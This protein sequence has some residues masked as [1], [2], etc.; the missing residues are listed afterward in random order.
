MAR[1]LA[2]KGN[3]VILM[4]RLAR[5]A[6]LSITIALLSVQGARAQGQPSS[7]SVPELPALSEECGT[8]NSNTVELAPLPSTMK[9]IKERKS[10][11]I[12]A[13]GS[14]TI[15]TG[16]SG[17]DFQSTLERSLE[18]AIKGLK[19]EV[20]NRGVS[21]E[22]ARDAAIRLTNEVALIGPDLVIWQVG[23]SDALARVPS[24]EFEET[25]RDTIRWLKRRNVDVVLVGAKYSRPISKDDRY[26]AVRFSVF[27]VAAQENVMRISQYRA[28]E[29]MVK[30]SGSN[31]VDA[32]QLSEDAYPCVA[33]FVARAVV[34]T[35][36]E[37]KPQPALPVPP[38]PPL[39]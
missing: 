14:P 4:Q 17:W 23:T 27:R 10:I 7:N 37:S 34:A 2:K 25:L 35:V 28:M 26:Q 24:D 12:L 38:A 32:Y 13:I 31:P 39:R 19:V 11:K 15:Q 33:Q 18:G 16:A 22:L 36:F 9:M 20:I 1:R 5:I 29:A 30:A 6:V 21:G 8:P 3:E